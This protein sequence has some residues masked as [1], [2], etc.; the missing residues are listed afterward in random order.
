MLCYFLQLFFHSKGNNINTFVSLYVC[1]KSVCWW[2]S[3][4][5]YRICI[6]DAC[7][8][9]IDR[10]WWTQ[11]IEQEIIYNDW[12]YVSL[13]L[14]FGCSIRCECYS[15]LLMY[16]SNIWLLK[17]R[18]MVNT[19]ID[20]LISWQIIYHLMHFDTKY[21]VCLKKNLEIGIM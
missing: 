15:L 12:N 8:G 17:V 7:Y 10:P 3:R 4:L 5:I 13:L 2:Y 1:K 19:C 16:F 14:H 6:I 21:I 11:W 18:M 9:Q 20:I